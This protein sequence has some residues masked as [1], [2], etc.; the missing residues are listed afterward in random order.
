METSRPAPTQP[1]IDYVRGLQRHL[2]LPDHLLDTHCVQRVGVPFAQLSRAQASSLID[3][4]KDWVAIPA[5][6]QRAMGQR[7]LPGMEAVR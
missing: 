3:E 7:D 4:L 2:H 5:E 6:L 1:Q